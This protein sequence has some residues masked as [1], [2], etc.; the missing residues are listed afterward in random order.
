MLRFENL[1]SESL[2]L[3]KKFEEDMNFYT[4]TSDK[5]KGTIGKKPKRQKPFDL[6]KELGT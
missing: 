6:E 5:L 2:Q 3:M 4:E 1:H